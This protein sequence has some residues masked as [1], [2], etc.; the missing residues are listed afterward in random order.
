MKKIIISILVLLITFCTFLPS[1]LAEESGYIYTIDSVSASLTSSGQR[2]TAE[3][4]NNSS[5]ATDDFIIGVAYSYKNEVLD[6]YSSPLSLDPSETDT[7]SFSITAD[8]ND[9]SYVKVFIWDSFETLTPLADECTVLPSKPLG[10]AVLLSV[11]NGNIKLLCDNG[12][13]Q[14]YTASGDTLSSAQ[15]IL[16][17]GATVKDRIVTY[18]LNS[19]TGELISI[20]KASENNEIVSADVTLGTYKLRTAKLATHNIYKDTVII[21]ATLAKSNPDKA[22]SYTVTDKTGLSDGEHYTGH[23][24][25]QGEFTSLA[26][27]TKIGADFEEDSRFAVVQEEAVPYYTEDDDECELVTVLAD[28]DAYRELLF[29][30][31]VYEE[32]NLEIGDAFFYTQDSNGFVNVSYKIYDYSDRTFTKPSD[33]M[34]GSAIIDSDWSYNLW[35]EGDNIQLT[36]GAI[37]EVTDSYIAFASLDQIKTGNL[38]TSLDLNYTHKDGIVQHSISDYATAYVY[39]INGDE[40]DEADKFKAKSISSVKASKLSTY[41]PEDGVYENIDMSMVNEALV[42]IVD[43][44]IVEIYVI[45]KNCLKT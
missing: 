3:V 11:K 5:H 42:M 30:T 28:G 44:E 32:Y 40:L 38:D 29:T 8:S 9:I 26:V 6:L 17:S 35:D 1:A 12:L 37:I 2:L 34:S 20:I 41:E 21:D 25:T 24:F 43:G 7:F 33:I 19:E 22:W 36:T 13:S 10:F 18:K 45:E 27:I 4:T 15:S 16:D 31:G 39:D 14:S 23:I